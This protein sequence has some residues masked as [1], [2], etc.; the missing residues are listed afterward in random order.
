M[1][2]KMRRRLIG[3]LLGAALLFGTAACAGAEEPWRTVTT[4]DSQLLAI[5]RFQNFD[6]QTRSFRTAV[7]V[8]GQRLELDGRIDFRANSGFA[9]VIGQGFAPQ[10]LLWGDGA[11][12]LAP[13]QGLATSSGG[14][15]PSTDAALAAAWNVRPLDP[16]ASTL[17]ALLLALLHLGVDRPDNPLLIQQSGALWLGETDVD[18][19][20]MQLFAGGVM[21]RVE[22]KLGEWVT[23]GLGSPEGTQ[24]D[25]DA[26]QGVLAQ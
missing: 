9:T 2:A 25:I 11:V 20:A 26:L 24:P 8:N 22:L 21:H 16:R 18:G 4:E 1:P 19:V 10:W 23:V 13:G 6:L 15:A 5:T 17:D 12:A 14:S 7:T 3:S